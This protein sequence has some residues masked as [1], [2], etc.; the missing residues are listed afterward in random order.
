[1]STNSPLQESGE[2]WVT[3]EDSRMY[4]NP[5]PVRIWHWLNAMGFVT[6]ILTGIQLRY[7]NMFNVLSFET[8]VKTHNWVAWAVM[9]A[10]GR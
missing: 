8:A 10:A 7:T 2:T 4:I 6:L 3:P 1:M 5:L 9:A